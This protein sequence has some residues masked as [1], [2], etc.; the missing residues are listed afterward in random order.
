[1]CSG[2]IC[3]RQEFKVLQSIVVLNAVAMVDLLI[4]FQSASK[5][6]SHDD[7]KLN[8]EVIANANCDVS[9]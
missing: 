2:V 4:R 1:M 7:T 8:Q 3:D 5:V 6:L 9:I